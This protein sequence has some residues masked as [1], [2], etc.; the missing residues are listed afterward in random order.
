[1]FSVLLGD[2][3]PFF[4][5]GHE[6]KLD[7]RYNWTVTLKGVGY[8]FTHGKNDRCCLEIT[9]LLDKKK[10]KQMPAVIALMFADYFLMP[11]EVP[12]QA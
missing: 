2:C 7:I 6:L 12:Q 4:N 8:K 10:Q 11:H 1:M 5:F 9:L 3:Q